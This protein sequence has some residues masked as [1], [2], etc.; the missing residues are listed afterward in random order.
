MDDFYSNNYKRFMVIPIIL[1]I[2]MFFLIFVAPGITQGMDF[3]GGNSILISTNKSLDSIKIENILKDFSLTEI[4]VSTTVS[5]TDFGAKIQYTDKTEIEAERLLALAEAALAGEPEK[6]IDYSKQVVKLI[7]NKSVQGTEALAV[8]NEA[9]DALVNYNESQTTNI[10]NQIINSFSLD[11][12]K[13]DF[14]LIKISP[15]LG[16]E[17]FNGIL[18]IAILG[19]ILISIVI[20]VAFREIGPSLAIIQAMVFDVIAGLCGM[21]L[22]GIPLSLSTI[23][24]LLMLVGYSVDTDIM[25]TSKVLKEKNGTASQRATASMKTGLTMTGTTL[26]ALAVMIVMSYMY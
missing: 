3:T 9:Q 20:F 5:P 1:L 17:S 16:S 18:I 21:A 14:K 2:P 24:A 25:L 8:L 6:S 13:T 22:L 23:P 19:M 7:S 10:K 15:T 11:S 4:K 26:S 12:S